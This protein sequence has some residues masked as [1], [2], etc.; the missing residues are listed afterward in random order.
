MPI[1]LTG[2]PKVKFFGADAEN[3]KKDHPS[4]GIIESRASLTGLENL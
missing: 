2:W 1:V 3:F 4:M